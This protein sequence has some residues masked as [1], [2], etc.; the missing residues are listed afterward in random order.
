[1]TKTLPTAT[2]WESIQRRTVTT[3]VASQVMGGVGVASGLAVM[4]LLA[5]RISG[6]EQASGLGSTAQVLG[7]ALFAI[8]VAHLMAR[9]G[10][11]PG[12]ILGYLLAAVG[13]LVIIAAAHISSFAL[14]LVGS[15]LF[16]AA[17]TSSN[18]A[19]YVGADLARPERRG[20]DI[21]IVVWATTL[22][23]VAGPNLVGP[24]ESVSDA[25]DLPRL[26]GSFVFSLIGFL[27]AA[28]VVAWRLRPD[29][30]ILARAGEGAQTKSP[31]SLRTGMRSVR[32]QPRA[33]LGLLTM[34]GGHTVMVSVMV[35]TPLHMNHGGASLELIGLVISVHI[36]G[37][38]AF[39]PITGWLVDRLGGPTVALGGTALLLTACTLAATTAEG[40]SASLTGALFLLGLGW[41]A[42][43][44]SGST[45][46]TSALS[47]HE[48]PSGQGVSD[49]TMGLC[50]A[51]GGALA[52]VIIEQFSYSALAVGGGLVATALAIV[53]V[54]LSSRP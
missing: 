15:L 53:V 24:A 14:L 46:L 22:G 23:S 32:T 25:L 54:V 51:S 27:L 31:T 45:M 5:L 19:R 36:L 47:V 12:L 6:S 37:M 38:F 52:G 35:M 49:L 2:E 8:P 41:S 10:R 33:L 40:M 30:L 48:R 50:G 44:V 34:A 7:S 28:G 1:M 16:G 9:R 17:T 18:Q 4:A 11:R 3:L 42:T 20:R 21:S 43:L 13:S 29:P 26:T 39:S